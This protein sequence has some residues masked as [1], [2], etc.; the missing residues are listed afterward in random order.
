MQRSRLVSLS[1]K[2]SVLG[3]QQTSVLSYQQTSVLS[4]PK[5]SILP[6]NQTFPLCQEQT[7]GLSQHFRCFKLS[8]TVMLKPQLSRYD[9][10]EVSHH[11][12]GSEWTKNG[13][14][15]GENGNQDLRLSPRENHGNFQVSGTSPTAQESAKIHP[16]LPINRPWRPLVCKAPTTTAVATTTKASIG[17][18]VAVR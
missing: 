3:L 15:W 18:E 16:K 4:Q 2:A 5:T 17:N 8:I 6:H 12:S 9:N 1:I 10:V 7:S 14:N 11:G 13:L